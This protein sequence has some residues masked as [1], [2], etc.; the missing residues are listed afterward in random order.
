MYWNFWCNVLD[1]I[2]RQFCRDALAQWPSKLVSERFERDY[3][4]AFYR[5]AASPSLKQP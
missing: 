5:L 1:P 3:R 4:F 2:Q